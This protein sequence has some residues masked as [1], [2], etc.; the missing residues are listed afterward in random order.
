[1]LI[2]AVQFCSGLCPIYAMQNDCS[3]VTLHKGVIKQ[4]K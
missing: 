3:V 2:F 1:V 4:Q